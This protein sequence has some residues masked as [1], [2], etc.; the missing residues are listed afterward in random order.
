DDLAGSLVSTA[1]A[2]AASPARVALDDA[3]APVEAVVDGAALV[4]AVASRFSTAPGD[5]AAIPR[6]VAAAAAGDLTSVGTQLLAEARDTT[7]ADALGWTLR[8]SQDL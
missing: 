1:E 4:T 7:R 2:L 8:C 6:I 5:V 3:G